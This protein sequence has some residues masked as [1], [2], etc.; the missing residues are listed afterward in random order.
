MSDLLAN[1]K[2]SHSPYFSNLLKNID[3]SNL[4]TPLPA[5]ASCPIAV[6]YSTPNEV[7]CYCPRMHMIVWDQA[8]A[9]QA[10]MACDAREVAIHEYL[11][12]LNAE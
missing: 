7:R 3:E 5:C 11:M 10:V 6:W 4:P 9:L 1:V 2:L 8:E 12:A